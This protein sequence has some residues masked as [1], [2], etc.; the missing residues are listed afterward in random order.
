MFVWYY[1]N[2]YFIRIP[3]NFAFLYLLLI[4]KLAALYVCFSGAFALFYLSDR[5]SRMSSFSGAKIPEQ[6]EEFR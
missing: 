4:F 2:G 1:F 5:W 6:G 3:Y